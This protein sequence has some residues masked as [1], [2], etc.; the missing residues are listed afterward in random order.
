MA[1]LTKSRF[2]AGLQ[3]RKRLWFEVNQP[4]TEP[5]VPTVPMLQGRAFDLI[6][7]TMKPGV[8]ISREAGMPAAITETRRVMASGGVPVLYQAAFRAGDLAVITDILRAQET[9]FALVE[10]KASTSVKPEH[11]AD[12]TFQA[13]VLRAA[14]IPVESV[15][16]GYVNNSFVLRETGNYAG[17]LKEEE[18]TAAVTALLPEVA[19][20]AAEYLGVMA[21]HEVPDIAMGAQCFAP[22]ECPFVGRCTREAGEGPEFPVELLPRGGKVAAALRA[23]GYQDLRQVPSELLDNETHR[24]VHGATVSGVAYFDGAVGQSLGASGY[25]KAYLDFETMAFAVPEVI[26]TSPYQQWPFQYSLHVEAADG[27]V[28][29]VNYLEVDGFGDFER[30]AAALV[31]A[32]PASGPVHVYNASLEAGVLTRLAE[33]LPAYRHKLEGILARIVDLLPLTRAAYYH[34]LMKG[35]WSIKAV[36]PTIDATLSY[37]NLGTIAEGDAAQGAFLELR[38]L[39]TSAARRAELEAG[40]KRYCERDTW[41][42][43]VLRRFLCGEG[44]AT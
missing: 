13:A 11:I 15:S 44:L 30:I 2:M 43:V 9:G 16:I 36:L 4:L 25:P 12:A 34:P 8:V 39:K 37:G 19:E 41:G 32:V 31:A 5:F 22:Y 10:V 3:C 26:G 35:S 29:H 23:A 40:L 7:Q 1:W 42:M 27:S 6:V 18:Q 20:Q 14:K 38:D 17:L 24:R 33:R 21:A 28:R